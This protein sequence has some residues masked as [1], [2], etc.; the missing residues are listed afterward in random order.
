M[1]LKASG[2][3]SY[4]YFNVSTGAFQSTIIWNAV[5][6]LLA[7]NEG[8]VVASMDAP[9]PGDVKDGALGAEAA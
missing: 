2:A 4:N 6:L 5:E 3:T 9:L 1:R 8:S 7:V